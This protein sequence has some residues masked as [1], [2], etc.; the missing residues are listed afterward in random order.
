MVKEVRR[1]L[2][3]YAEITD[4]LLSYG[5]KIEIAVPE[6]MINKVIFGSATETKD[7]KMLIDVK[8]VYNIEPQPR[9]V[10]ATYFNKDTMAHKY[11]N[12]PA[13]FMSAALVE[14]CFDH[15]ILLPKTARKQFDI[16]DLTVVLDIMSDIETGKSPG[17]S[18]SLEE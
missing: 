11:L 5:K 2:F 17:E 7:I 13:D 14:Y 3:S 8:Q 1:I 6:G 10:V 18:L 12:L 9:S 4:A 15:K 16:S